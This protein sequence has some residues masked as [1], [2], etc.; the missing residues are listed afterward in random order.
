MGSNA[1]R[2]GKLTG[3]LQIRGKNT[4]VSPGPP[5]V[6]TAAYLLAA[7]SR[8]NRTS[9]GLPVFGSI[10]FGPVKVLDVTGRRLMERAVGAV[11]RIVEAVAAENGPST[12]RWLARLIVDVVEAS[13]KA[14]P[15]S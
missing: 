2:K 1:S 15:S 9:T 14:D 13:A 8:W 6:M 7:S 4:S 12:L 5:V 10:A 11:E 3:A